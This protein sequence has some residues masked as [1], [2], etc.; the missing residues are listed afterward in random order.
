MP[1]YL[2]CKRHLTLETAADM[3]FRKVG[4]KLT[5]NA[6]QTKRTKASNLLW[7]QPEI[8]NKK[9]PSES[10]IV[11]GKNYQIHVKDTRNL[12][13]LLL[14]LQNVLIFKEVLLMLMALSA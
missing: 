7:R 2:V 9:C 6:Q 12:P 4:D 13:N 14:V 5:H 11:R 10:I 8:S 1:G 3:L